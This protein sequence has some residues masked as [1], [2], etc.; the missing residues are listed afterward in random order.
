MTSVSSL[1]T[2]SGHRSGLL[3]RSLV[4]GLA[5]LRRHGQTIAE[6]LLVLAW[7]LFVGR[8]FLDMNPNMIPWGAEFPMETQSHY[9]WTLLSRCGTCVFWNGFADGG[10]PSFVD[11]NGSILHPL[12]VLTTLI[13]GV[14][15]GSKV[16]M[17]A[18]LFLAGLAQWWLAKTL[19]LGVAARMWCS[20]MA[21]V[22]GHL[23]GRLQNGMLV[24]V[25]SLVFASLLIPAILNLTAKPSRRSALLL[26][27]LFALVL[28]S[29]QG[30]VQVGTLLGV[31][32]AALV[33]WIDKTSAIGHLLR[34]LLLA[35]LVAL[36]LSAV[37]WVPLLHFSPNVVKDGDPT[38][39]YSQP[40]EYLPLNLVIRDQSFYENPTLD[41]LPAPVL[42]ILYIGWLPILLAMVTV[43]WGDSTRNR[44]LAF[45]LIAIFL[46]FFFS[47]S[48][49]MRALDKVVPG[50]A[51]YI[52]HP[53]LIAGIAVP[54]I[55]G[56][57]AWG[58]DL[59]LHADWLKLRLS[60]RRMPDL[61]VNAIYLI[62]AIPLLVSIRTAYDFAEKYYWMNPLP[63]EYEPSI[64]V[65]VT[66]SAEWVAP[67]FGEYL[68]YPM[69]LGRGLKLGNTFRPW[70]WKDHPD[71]AF[72]VEGTRDAAG[73]SN[74][75]YVV[76]YSGVNWMVHTQNEYAKV[77][78]P[79]GEQVAC[80]AVSQG[81]NIDVDCQTAVD[82]VLAVTE[83]ATADW[84]AATD[85]ISA[86]LLPG[87]WL[88]VPAPAGTHHYSFRYRPWDVWV[89][90]TLALLG[91]ILVIAGFWAR[92]NRTQ[93]EVPPAGDP[94][95]PDAMAAMTD[96]PGL[97]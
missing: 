29:G 20:F 12:T 37:L 96:D 8:E 70:R 90:L 18:C 74:P 1:S 49:G 65:L 92:D 14:V 59:M 73:L 63:A 21:V 95:D 32:P 35:G 41:K 33:Y 86:S 82:G 39:S 44:R 9:V 62:A 69:T 51:P 85:S 93:A 15:N 22:G 42:N 38:L 2:S 50:I 78:L 46:V 94:T 79:S 27:V 97:A 24:L 10:S 54:L 77:V 64:P 25:V 6:L 40:L 30:Y 68:W 36:L 45:L 61:D 55:L 16:T 75:D 83:N 91:V 84:R 60:I 19:R 3:R 48:T 4:A 87:Q 26:G 72:Y 67:P 43:A 28:L 56:L 53:S 71:P 47:S 23:A 31:L 5:F 7:A 81:G 57:A 11:L 88:S 66:E 13:W 58:L 52:R 17:V 76:T 34:R 80:A 89:G